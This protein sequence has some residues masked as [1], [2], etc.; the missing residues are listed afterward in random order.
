[1]CPCPCHSD[2]GLVTVIPRCGGGGGLCVFDYAAGA[3]V[4]VERGAGSDM[5]VVLAGETLHRATNHAWLPGM[6]EVPRRPPHAVARIACSCHS[7]AHHLPGPPSL[8]SLVNCGGMPWEGVLLTLSSPGSPPRRPA[9][10]G[11]PAAVGAIVGGTRPDNAVRPCHR[12][13]TGA[14]VRRARDLRRVRGGA[15]REPRLEQLSPRVTLFWRLSSTVQID[16]IL[17]ID[18][19]C[20]CE[21]IITTYRIL[22]SVRI[23][24]F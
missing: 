12:G 21:K 3:W 19:F 15:Q 23:D 7:S 22:V 5:C 14:R 1:M 18:A 10:V 8:C 20:G 6:H 13:A 17:W 2:V 24:C 4:D 16:C 11:G 9:H